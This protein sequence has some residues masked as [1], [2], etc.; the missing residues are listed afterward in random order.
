M[1]SSNREQL[2]ALAR[3]RQLIESAITTLSAHRN[4]L[5]EGQLKELKRIIYEVPKPGV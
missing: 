1:S 2:E 5:T 3:E 4:R